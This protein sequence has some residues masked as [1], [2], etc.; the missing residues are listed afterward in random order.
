LAPE[1]KAGTC[2]LRDPR[3][4][5]HQLPVIF[6]YLLRACDSYRDRAFFPSGD[7]GFRRGWSWQ[8]KQSKQGTIS[9]FDDLGITYA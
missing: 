4:I 2:C 8:S 3:Q 1:V 9:I 7:V 6:V 5:I